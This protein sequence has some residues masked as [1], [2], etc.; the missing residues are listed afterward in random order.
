[1]TATETTPT[2]KAAAAMGG[3]IFLTMPLAFY[4]DGYVLAALWRWFVTPQWDVAPLGVSAA[5]GVSLLFAYARS[6]LQ[7]KDT[8][9]PREQGQAVLWLMWGAPTCVLAFGW[10]LHRWPVQ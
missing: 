8:R 6:R 5:A 4:Y 7:P 3:A 1:M 2:D 10:M 9:T